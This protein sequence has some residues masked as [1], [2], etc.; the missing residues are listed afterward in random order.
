M[1]VTLVLTILTAIVVAF[2]AA[3][4]SAF[5]E[6]AELNLLATTVSAPLGMV[7]LAA[8]IVLLMALAATVAWTYT[9]LLLAN[10]AHTR[11]ADRL[12]KI[13]EDVEAS[14]LAQLRSWLEAEL[15]SHSARGSEASS[16]LM[17]RLDRLEQALRDS[18]EQ[19]ENSLAAYIGEL[20]DRL[21]RKVPGRDGL[22]PPALDRQR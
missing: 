9:A 15:Q 11:E 2:A 14:R 18:Q 4:W 6:P 3:N 10:R 1:K 16:E 12:R 17:Q 5:T 8:I 7:L 20:E 19:G 13:S 22:P 21:D